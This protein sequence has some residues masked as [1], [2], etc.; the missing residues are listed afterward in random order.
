[1]IWKEKLQE[2]NN[3]KYIDQIYN[4]I[5][6][7]DILIKRSTLNNEKEITTLLDRYYGIDTTIRLQS[8][9]KIT[10]QEK[11]LQYS[12][13]HYN[14]LTIE[15]MNNRT[16]RPQGD[17]FSLYA[18][19]YVFGYTTEKEDGLLKY[20]IFDVPR[21]MMYLTYEI[22]VDVLKQKYLRQNPAPAMS[23]FFAIPIEIL[24]DKNLVVFH[25]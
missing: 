11:I 22:G 3:S 14:Q 13:S 12:K 23:S 2:Q 24:I 17:W 18:Q 10:T 1:M 6:G 8:G 20:W 16:D 15:Y 5:F 19:Y 25:G 4:K 9:C 21:L 7:E